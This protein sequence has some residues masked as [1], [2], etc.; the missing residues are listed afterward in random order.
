MTTTWLAVIAE[1]DFPEFARRVHGLRSSYP[2]YVA[3]LDRIEADWLAGSP[4]S[5]AVRVRVTIADLDRYCGCQEQ[6]CAAR[7]LVRLAN[8][9]HGGRLWAG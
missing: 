4:D 5:E 6:G 7:E 1:C 8:L 2:A 9:K 3:E